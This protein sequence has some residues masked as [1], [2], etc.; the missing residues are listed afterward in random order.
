MNFEMVENN[1]HNKIDVPE[2]SSDY[3]SVCQHLFYITSI[4]QQL[5]FRRLKSD[6]YF[7][8]LIESI[9]KN[10]RGNINERK[11]IGIDNFYMFSTFFFKQKAITYV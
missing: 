6:R 10:E 9:K 2:L 4:R 3:V 7:Y 1:S 8:K 5:L 11:Y